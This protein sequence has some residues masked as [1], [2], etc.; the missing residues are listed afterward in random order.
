MWLR[1]LW[2]ISFFPSLISLANFAFSSS[3][4]CKL[5]GSFEEHLL[6][7]LTYTLNN[8]WMWQATFRSRELLMMQSSWGYSPY[9]IRDKIKRWLNSLEPNFIAIWNALAEKFLT[10]YFPTSYENA[11]M[12]NESPQL[13]QLKRNHS[14]KHVKGLKT[15]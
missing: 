5:W 3:E 14:W 15:C 2:G 1:N 7:T 10:K 4:C 12:R 8:L 9:A 6:K 11:R 13:G